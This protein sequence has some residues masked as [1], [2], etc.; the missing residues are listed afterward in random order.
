MN[1]DAIGATAEV[2]GAVGVIASLAYLAFQIRLNS[3]QISLNTVQIESSLYQTTN[4]TFV[5]WYALLANN[6]ELAQIWYAQILGGA[7][8]PENQHRARA[9][10]SVFFLALENNYQHQER[11]MVTRRTLEQPGIGALFNSPVVSAWLKEDGYRIITPKFMNEI[12]RI[13][14]KGA[15]GDA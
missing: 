10:L 3:R 7:V 9:L 2:T 11:G 8:P 15:S 5:N 13:G 14:R 6:S 4:D 1:W 12:G